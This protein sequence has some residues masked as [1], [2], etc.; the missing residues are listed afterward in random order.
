MS[1]TPRLNVFLSVSISCL[2]LLSLSACR[3]KPNRP[4]PEP[5]RSQV[6]PTDTAT[7]TPV[8]KE[9]KPTLVGIRRLLQQGNSREALSLIRPFLLEDPD[10][11]EVVF[12][13]AQAEHASGNSKQAFTLLDETAERIPQSR[14]AIWSFGSQLALESGE[15]AQTLSYLQRIIAE[16][17]QQVNALRKLAL[18]QN[19]MGHRAEGN[20]N[21]RRLLRRSPMTTGDLYCLLTPHLQVHDSQQ[22]SI[23]MPYKTVAVARE[24]LEANRHSEALRLL[25]EDQNEGASNAA[26]ISLI[27][28][29]QTEMGAF[30]E[31][32][33]TLLGSSGECHLQ[34]DHWI[35]LGNC[36]LANHERERAKQ[37]FLKAVALEPL[38]TSALRR[39][40]VALAQLGEQEAADRVNERSALARDLS[41]LASTIIERKGDLARSCEI[42]ANQLKDVGLPFQSLAWHF[43]AIA[44]SNPRMARVDQ[45][46]Q[47][48]EHLQATVSTEEAEKLQRVGLMEPMLDATDWSSLA[49]GFSK[50]TAAKT[51]EPV[52]DDSSRIQ[53]KFSNVA[54]EIG[55]HFQYRNAN[56]PVTKHFLLH[57]PLGA[58]VACLDYDLD[59]WVDVYAAQGDGDGRLPGASPNFLARNLGG[60]FSSV[61][62]RA[63]ADDR[64][65]SMGLTC[66]DINQD[67]FADLVVGNMQVNCLYVNQGDGTFERKDILG[68]WQDATYTTGLAI[69]DVS[70]DQLPDVVEVNYVAD[71]RIFNPIQFDASGQPIRLPG[72]MQFTAGPDRLF[73]ATKD[74]G[75]ADG[76][77]AGEFLDPRVANGAEPHRAMGLVVGDIDADEA[78]EVFIA[79]DQTLNQLWEF[80]RDHDSGGLARSEEAILRGVAG[81]VAGQPLASMGIAAADFNQDQLLD[82]QVTNFDDELSNLYLQQ[83][84]ASFRDA[85]FSTGLDLC[86]RTMLGFGTQAIDFENDGDMDL[87]VGNGD[88]EDNRPNKSSFKMPTQL[89]V[90]HRQRFVLLS[91]EL[92][93][94][95][96]R[97]DHLARAVAKLD[98]NRDGLVDVLIGDVMDPLALLENQT[99]T[100]NGFVQLQ[101]VGTESERDAIGAIVTAIFSECETRHFVLTGDGYM[102]RNEAMVQVAIPK[103]RELRR[104]V[105]NWPSGREQAFDLSDERRRGLIVESQNRVHWFQL[106]P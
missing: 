93:E 54:A 56:P 7:Q 67:G 99:D 51:N 50:E 13:A 37:A 79:N 31:A 1:A 105:V 9:S 44:Y 19:Q 22:S 76:E 41:E 106:A 26:S 69:A 95:Y 88:I 43:N 47:A 62:D 14:M 92:Q 4:T 86:S 80:D 68:N 30:Q 87:V 97:Q 2:L 23:P 77:W 6:E 74:G 52:A 25:Q 10:R 101:L 82:L 16:D 94:G 18:L 104:I 89:L 55:L 42:L 29:I 57:Q 59:G 5:S 32:T 81:G 85:V 58:G 11:I 100:P 71:S 8:A 98:W 102:S 34:P 49:D 46:L 45:H 64:G 84:D 20:V 53:P 78:N 61:A 38:H 36:W 27:A 103:D 12:L 66:G 70:G 48:I 33:K 75:W 35:A 63:G 39:L 60:H 21:L 90:N 28:R 83:K 91:E 65:Y 24:L 3:P 17:P 15:L 96:L 72:P 40:A 73:V